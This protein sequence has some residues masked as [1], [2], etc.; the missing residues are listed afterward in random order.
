MN[1][2]PY[3]ALN[4]QDMGCDKF[5]K[6]VKEKLTT[7]RLRRKFRFVRGNMQELQQLL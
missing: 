5:L 4:Q 3:P 7:S 6:D 1:K 2:K